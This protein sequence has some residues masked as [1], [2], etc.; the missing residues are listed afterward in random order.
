MKSILVAIL[1]LLGV[2]GGGWCCTAQRKLS[3]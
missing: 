2:N 3:G 1:L